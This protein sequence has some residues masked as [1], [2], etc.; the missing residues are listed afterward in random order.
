MSGLTPERFAALTA[1]MSLADVEWHQGYALAALHAFAAGVVPDLFAEVD[2]HV[3]RHPKTPPLALWATLAAALEACGREFAAKAAAVPGDVPVVA[4]EL[5]CG[6]LR[7][8]MRR[9]EAAIPAPR[10]RLAAFRAHAG[11]VAD[12]IAAM[13]AQTDARAREAGLVGQERPE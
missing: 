8:E 12:E 6:F 1:G 13:A 4:A 2:R 5:F 10:A 3:R 7:A 11:A 9:F